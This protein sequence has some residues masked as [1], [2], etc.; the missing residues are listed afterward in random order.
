MKS[1]DTLTE[2]INDLK[3]DGYIEDF[4]LKQNCLECR[5][6]QYK[7]FHNEFAIDSFYR[8]EGDSSPDD[9]MILYAISS[10]KYNLKG[11][12]INAYGMYADA[13]TDEMLHSLKTSYTKTNPNF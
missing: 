12:L 1:Y 2:G 13:I 9:E 5:N 11:V 7:I 8:F 4:N 10:E 3:S 6:G